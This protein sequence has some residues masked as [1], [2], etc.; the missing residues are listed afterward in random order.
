MSEEPKPPVPGW[1]EESAQRL[2][3]AAAVRA[4]G[5]PVYPTRYGPGTRAA[6]ASGRSW[7]R[8]ATRAWRP[9]RP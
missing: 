5:L 2:E 4:M 7:P 1:P 9:S 3:K 8:M 6:I